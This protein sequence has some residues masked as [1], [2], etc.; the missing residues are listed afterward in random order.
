MHVFQKNIFTPVCGDTKQV[1]EL[2]DVFDIGGKKRIELQSHSSLTYL[3]VGLS[4]DIDI[5]IVTS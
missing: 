1:L 3:V 5:E 4:P 2:V